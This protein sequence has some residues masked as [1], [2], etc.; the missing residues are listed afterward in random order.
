MH[1]AFLLAVVLMLVGC[2]GRDLERKDAVLAAYSCG[3]ADGAYLATH[4]GCHRVP[5]GLPN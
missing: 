3:M 1:R 4:P 5:C 2:A